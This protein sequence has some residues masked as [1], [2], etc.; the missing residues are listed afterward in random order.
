MYIFDNLFVLLFCFLCVF[1]TQE[2][3]T[4]QTWWRRWPEEIVIL[5]ILAHQE[6]LY[7]A[8]WWPKT[9]TNV[10]FMGPWAVAAIHMGC[11]FGGVDSLSD[12]L[13]SDEL[14]NPERVG[15]TYNP[16][17][18]CPLSP[19]PIHSNPA[20]THA[21]RPPDPGIQNLNLN[22]M[23]IKSGATGRHRTAQDATG[24]QRG[25]NILDPAH[26]KYMKVCEIRRTLE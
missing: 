17:L 12:L 26:F 19:P 10:K 9:K 16:L 13:K 4:Q 25:A 20:S 7:S 5:M 2:Q 8:D 6:P 14:L 23:G 15:R 18:P 24:R 21:S 3:K 22:I 11:F 1:Y